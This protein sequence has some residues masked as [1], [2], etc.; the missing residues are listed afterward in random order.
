MWHT[1]RAHE[2]CLPHIRVIARQSDQINRTN[3]AA[4]GVVLAFR[5][6]FLSPGAVL[7]KNSIT[8]KL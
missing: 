7:L 4:P 5:A 1:A 3:V 8:L 6:A 2:Q